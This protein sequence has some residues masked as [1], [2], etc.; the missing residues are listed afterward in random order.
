MR[1]TG[2]FIILAL[3]ASVVAAG[4]IDDP[5]LGMK[6]AMLDYQ[7]GK[8]EEAYKKFKSRRSIFSRRSQF[9]FPIHGGKIVVYGGRIRGGD[10]D[11]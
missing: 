9:I 4:Y 1:V 6:E 5:A 10:N 3:F 7:N 11:V 8:Y 2:I